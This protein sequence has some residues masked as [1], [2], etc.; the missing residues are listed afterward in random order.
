MAKRDRT[1]RLLA[2]W[3]LVFDALSD[4][5]RRYVLQYLYERP[6]PVSTREL[7]LALACRTTDRA[8]D[9]IDVQIVEQAEVGFVHV[10]LP[11]LEAADLVEWSGDQVTLTDH[12]ETLPL[13]TPSYR[14]VVRPEETGEE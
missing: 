2:D 7:A 1:E 12:A 14:G 5:S 3:D 13:F 4:S 8:P 9:N 11:K 10:H 6:D